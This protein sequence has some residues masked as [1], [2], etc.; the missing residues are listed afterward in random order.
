MLFSC[1]FTTEPLPSAQERRVRGKVGSGF[2]WLLD[3]EREV[4]EVWGLMKVASRAREG[5]QG[6]ECTT[7]IIIII[8][9]RT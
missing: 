1:H 4:K 3:G 9:M 5:L 2:G 6:G 7:T 8:I